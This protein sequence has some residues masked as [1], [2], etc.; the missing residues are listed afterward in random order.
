MMRKKQSTMAAVVAVSLISRLMRFMGI[1]VDDAMEARI[2]KE[3]RQE[4]H[5]SQ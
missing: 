3:V 5:F 2:E 4:L 1:S